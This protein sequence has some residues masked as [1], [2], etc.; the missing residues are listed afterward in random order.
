MGEAKIGTM[1]GAPAPQTDPKSV[2]GVSPVPT[3]PSRSELVEMELLK[4]DYVMPSNYCGW[5]S[6]CKYI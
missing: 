1:P 3:S 4:R 6:I 2:N 5:Y